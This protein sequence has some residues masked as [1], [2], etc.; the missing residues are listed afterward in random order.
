MCSIKIS[1]TKSALQEY[2]CNSKFALWTLHK[3]CT[4]WLLVVARD[5]R[6]ISKQQY[7]R[8]LSVTDTVGPDIFSNFLLQ[9]IEVCLL[10]SGVKNV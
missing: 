4:V 6:Y 10:N 1:L 9:Y 3:L 5:L 7:S 8:N 2:N